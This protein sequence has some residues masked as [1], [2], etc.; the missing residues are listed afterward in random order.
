MI[1]IAPLKCPVELQ[2]HYSKCCDCKVIDF[3]EQQSHSL[4][5]QLSFSFAGYFEPSYLNNTL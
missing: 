3:I 5:N 4:D 2:C 1:V